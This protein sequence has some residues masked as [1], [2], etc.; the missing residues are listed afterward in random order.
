MEQIVRKAFKAKS[1]ILRQVKQLRRFE[2]ASVLRA[3]D[4]AHHDLVE[5]LMDSALQYDNGFENLFSECLHQRNTRKMEII[6]LLKSM[7][8]KMITKDAIG[9]A[10]MD[11][12]AKSLGA[13]RGSWRE[14]QRDFHIINNMVVSTNNLIINSSSTINQSSKHSLTQSNLSV[15]NSI[16]HNTSTSY[17]L[18][19]LS[20]D[21]S[22]Q[23]QLAVVINEFTHTQSPIPF[24][25]LSAK[26][27]DRNGDSDEI[28]IG[29][30]SKSTN[31]PPNDDLCAKMITHILIQNGTYKVIRDY[32]KGTKADKEV[33]LIFMSL[34]RS[35]DIEG[36][37][38]LHSK[39]LESIARQLTETSYATIIQRL[40][41]GTEKGALIEWEDDGS[42][43]K[44]H[45]SRRYRVAEKYAIREPHLYKLKRPIYLSEPTYDDNQCILSTSLVWSMYSGLKKSN[46]KTA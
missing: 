28:S 29:K 4:D 31:I 22:S 10:L 1:K 36:Y 39:F 19:E 35:R 9:I 2:F 44:D 41:T 5:E 13:T 24:A 40:L 34:M 33:A 30:N 46:S 26:S 20:S 15:N 37:K 23:S 8:P 42:Y 27:S 38:A 6:D 17:V 14:Q 16:N 43:R 11:E 3:I 45:Y 32:T 18:S 25:Q 7:H 21:E 12:D